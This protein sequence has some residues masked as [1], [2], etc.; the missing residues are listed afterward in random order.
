MAGTSLVYLTR[1]SVKLLLAL[2]L[3][4]ATAIPA[5]T[6]I[7]CEANINGFKIHNVYI[8]GDQY[9]GVAWA[10]KHLSEETCLTPVTD[11]SKADAILEVYSPYTSSGRQ[12]T[13]DTSLSVSCTSN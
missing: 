4:A 9:N 11:I 3:L 12:S 6:Q 10:Y 2:L 8:M 5:H 7:K 13:E 1:C